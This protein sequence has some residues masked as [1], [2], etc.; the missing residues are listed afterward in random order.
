[1]LNK[2]LD[3]DGEEL[4]LLLQKAYFWVQFRILWLV[5]E[6]KKLIDLLKIRHFCYKNCI[7]HLNLEFWNFTMWNKIL[8]YDGEELPLLLQKEHF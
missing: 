7:F 4:P 1:M 8:D 5:F 2:I 6:T 3:C